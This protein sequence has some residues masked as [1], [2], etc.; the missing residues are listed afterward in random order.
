MGRLLFS[1]LIQFCQCIIRHLKNTK[2]YSIEFLR[3]EM[4]TDP[5]KYHREY[6]PYGSYSL[7]QF[8]RSDV[9]SIL[10]NSIK[11]SFVFFKV[12]DSCWIF[13][14]KWS[15]TFRRFYGYENEEESLKKF[16]HDRA[17]IHLPE[18]V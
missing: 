2:L 7:F 10:K 14:T 11:Y 9:I 3:T 12:V 5:S 4:T 8:E 17:K 6:S 1:S 16:C 15:D 18:G 13:S